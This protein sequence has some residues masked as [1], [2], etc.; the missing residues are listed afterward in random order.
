MNTFSRPV[1]HDDGRTR[2][3]ALAVI[4]DAERAGHRRSGDRLDA[5][6]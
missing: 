3:G 6:D 5:S 1:A 4:D 2:G